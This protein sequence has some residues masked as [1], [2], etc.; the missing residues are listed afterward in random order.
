MTGNSIP[1]GS[2]GEVTETSVRYNQKPFDGGELMKVYLAALV[3]LLAVVAAGFA[4]QP[5]TKPVPL[6]LEVYTSSPNGF[7]VILR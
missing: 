3:L 7:S 5:Q 4:S 2:G 1:P 6:H